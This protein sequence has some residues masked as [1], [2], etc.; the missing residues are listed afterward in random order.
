LEALNACNSGYRF[1]TDVSGLPLTSR[2]R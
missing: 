1:Q 2:E